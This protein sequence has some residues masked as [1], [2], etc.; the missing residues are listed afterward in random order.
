[1][2]IN[3]ISGYDFM[4]VP[5]SNVY[6]SFRGAKSLHKLESGYQVVGN[7]FITRFQ[8]TESKTLEIINVF[9]NLT[10]EEIGNREFEVLYTNLKEMLT[11]RG[12]VFEDVL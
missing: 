8:T 6:C 1:M 5:L 3:I 7:A 9:K 4:D 2:G 12:C 10:N 11:E